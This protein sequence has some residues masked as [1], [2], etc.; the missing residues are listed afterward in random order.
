MDED[1]EIAMERLD[2]GV[3]KANRH[4]S[5]IEKKVG[6]S[7]HQEDIIEGLDT[8]EG[9]LKGI[10]RGL[11]RLG[12]KVERTNDEVLGV[13]KAINS[14]EAKTDRT[15]AILSSISD[16]L[17]R[18]NNYLKS[19]NRFAGYALAAMLTTLF[20]FLIFELALA[21][22]RF[23][24]VGFAPGFV[25]FAAYLILIIASIALAMYFAY[26]FVDWARKRD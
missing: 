14:L 1:T 16:K 24:G 11:G 17:D 18:S 6:T 20:S 4:L 5:L 9:T 7:K 10:S 19:I 13:H 23:A 26:V 2:E 3:R 15:N 12:S 22:L 21:I 8:A 25:A